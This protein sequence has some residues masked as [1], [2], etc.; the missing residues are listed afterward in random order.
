M[1]SNLFSPES[2]LTFNLPLFSIRMIL[3]GHRFFTSLVFVRQFAPHFCVF[4]TVTFL[5]ASTVC[6]Q[7]FTIG[8]KGGVAVNW[9]GF[10]DKIQKDT[11]STRPS[12]GYS[13]GFQIGFPLKKDFQLMLE[14]GYV[15][16]IRTITFDRDRWVN[17][18]VFNMAE[19]NML[20]RKTYR[21]YLEKNIPSEWFFEVGPE[22]NYVINANGKIVVND[23]LPNKYK[24]VYEKEPDYSFDHMF[25]E[26]GNRWLFGLALGVGFKA[27]LRRNQFI[28][29]QLRFTSGHTF[30]G[31]KN[32]SSTINI[33]GFEDTLITN[34]KSV[35]VSAAY[36]LDFDVQQ[37][38]KG[39]STLQKKI[40]RGK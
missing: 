16:K 35:S 38:R 31:K 28:T 10:G 12:F 23:G 37:S 6:G 36:T 8:L 39:K 33:F 20:L 13:G 3:K 1:C 14:G 2:N 22:I 40:K 5:C 26:N 27:P 30:L 11:F 24:V 21:F 18:T 25:Y 19:G 29:T 32:S 17:S 4:V 9:A 15:R 7:K 34:N